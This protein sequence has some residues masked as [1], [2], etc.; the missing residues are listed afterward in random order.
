MFVR[1][2][3]RNG[4]S[5]VF[6]TIGWIGVMALS[7]CVLAGASWATETVRS[8]D[9]N[10]RFSF[11]PNDAGIGE[12]WFSTE[13]D[14]TSWRPVTVPHTWQ[15]EPENTGY[16]GIAW[17][18][19]SIQDD[20]AWEDKTLRLEFD[21]IYRD[22]WIWINGKRVGEHLG[23]GWTPF[24]F[25]IDEAWK[26]GKEN[27]VIVRVDNRF[28]EK[29]L[30]YLR[31]SDWAADGG[32]IRRV[33]LRALP[34]AHIERVQVQAVPTAG[35]TAAR[36]KAAIQVSIPRNKKTDYCLEAILFGPEGNLVDSPE[37]DTKIS[38]A[39]ESQSG[40]IETVIEGTVDRPR[41]WHFDEPHLYRILVRL[42][43]KDKQLHERQV[44]FGIRSIELKD[45][46][47]FLNGE[48]MRLMGVEW[49]P[50]SD[51]RY[52]MA[53]SP[54]FMQ[55]VLRD[56]KQLNCLLTRFHW[57][58]D[59]SVF[60]FCDRNG[61]LVQ[62]EVPSWGGETMKGN[63]E[64]IQERHTR[65]MIEA[66]YNHPSIFAWGLCN[67]IGG[68]SE[69]AHEFIAEGQ[70]LA[71]R[72]DPYRPLTYA[73]NSLQSDHEKDAAR[74]LDFIEWNDYYE[75]WY[76]GTVRDVEANLDKIAKAFPGKSLIISEYGLCEC[77]P[78][79]PTSDERRI[80]ILKTHTDAYRK[81]PN[82]AGAI[83]FDYNDYRTHIGDKGQGAFQQRVHGVVDLLGQRK[84]SWEALRRESSPIR[85]L[86]VMAP[87]VSDGDTSSVVEIVTRSLENDLP[88]Y[89]LRNYLLVW[90]AYNRQNLPAGTGKRVLPDLPPGAR[91]SETIQWPT[92]DSL[93][94][95]HVQVFRPTGYSVL[96]GEWKAAP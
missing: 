8:L 90:V 79:N 49:M 70:K 28:S 24:G 91:H 77:D 40:R 78:K 48:P 20:S 5:R 50:G 25:S 68:Q 37:S 94:R 65:E 32:I 80:E 82:V 64:G 86:T 57:Q 89:T 18:A 14:R 35:N 95:I 83:F 75:S 38:G 88:A 13:F 56:M 34:R 10:W 44:S 55:G 15:V 43:Q 9:G 47:F 96:D 1:N 17:Y 60:E 59:D 81:A 93:T 63:F 41:L 3:Y 71:R 6:R 36:W 30:P 33:R 2:T 42:W 51:P 19:R 31:S 61:I 29:A 53:E 66:H 72:F 92:G 54:E 85:S 22:A 58:Q 52:G 76:G 73:S 84:P 27:L 62:E 26:P 23:S 45:G 74:L 12:T 69:E 16:Y 67:E 87:S 4:F 11:D 39:E 21:A 7:S 46:F